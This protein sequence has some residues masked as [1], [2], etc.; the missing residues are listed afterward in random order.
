MAIINIHGS[1]WSGNSSSTFLIIVTNVATNRAFYLE[2]GEDETINVCF[3]SESYKT[4]V[5][6]LRGEYRVRA[7][8]LR[9]HDHSKD[10]DFDESYDVSIPD[11]KEKG[12]ARLQSF[13][14]DESGGLLRA[15]W[16]ALVKDQSSELEKASDAKAAYPIQTKHSSLGTW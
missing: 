15:V 14:A 16:N 2:S 8:K 3:N 10:G 6:A 1:V 11:Q 12:V 7:E 5:S 4:G 13:F 9:S